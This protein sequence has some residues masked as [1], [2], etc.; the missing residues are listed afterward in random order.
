MLKLFR[1]SLALSILISTLAAASPAAAACA[2]PYTVVGG[3]TLSGIS[4]KCGTTV[5]AIQSANGLTTTVIRIGQQLTIPGGTAAPAGT[6]TTTTVTTT[7]TH[8]V[9]SG[10]TLFGLA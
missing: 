10:D 5:A 9:V 6:T 8:T 2:S 3:D 4:V 7:G 1:I